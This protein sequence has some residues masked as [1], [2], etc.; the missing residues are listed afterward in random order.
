MTIEVVD[1]AAVVGVAMVVDVSTGG[2]VVVV[3]AVSAAPHP[4]ASSAPATSTSI[5]RLIEVP[6]SCVRRVA[7]GR[8]NVT[9]PPTVPRRRGPPSQTRVIGWRPIPPREMPHS[10]RD[11][12]GILPGAVTLSEILTARSPC[13]SFE[14]F[15]PKDEDG[16]ERLLRTVA[17]SSPGS[18]R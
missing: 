8:D 5:L 7:V 6:F 13:F 18:S 3:S 4:A 11:A 2:S 14:F 15:P 9:V 16:V 12:V 10:G 1:V 17:P